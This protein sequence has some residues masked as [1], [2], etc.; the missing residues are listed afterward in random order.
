MGMPNPL[1][2]GRGPSAPRRMAPIPTG[3][4]MRVHRAAAL[5][6]LAL[7]TGCASGRVVRLETG[8]GPPVVFTPDSGDAE[9]VEVERHEFKQAV[10]R[11]ARDMRPP[12]NPQQAAR[13]L[14]GVDA[15][16][17]AYFFNQRTRQLTPLDGAALASDTWGWTPSGR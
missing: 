13:H 11:L 17:G 6:L 16:G 4:L 8:R 10:A 3:G 1:G 9:P 14:M 7:V 15:R 12:A 2:P 5:L